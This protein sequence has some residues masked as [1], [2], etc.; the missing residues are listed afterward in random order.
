[1]DNTLEANAMSLHDRS[2]RDQ[3]TTSNDLVSG[4]SC[5]CGLLGEGS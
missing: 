5:T 3:H 1:M 4:P 2:T